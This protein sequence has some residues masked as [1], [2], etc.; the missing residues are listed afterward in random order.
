MKVRPIT[1]RAA[2]EFVDRLHRH[3]KRPQG[4]KFSLCLMVEAVMVGVVMVG[5]PVSRKCDDGLT[6]EV[7]RLCTDGTPNAASKLYGAARRVCGAMGYD[8]VLTFTLDS[9][10]GTSLFAA[11]WEQVGVTSGKSW[12]VASRPRV[13][14]HKLEPRKKWSANCA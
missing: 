5:R 6:A 3:H 2:C 10:P 13:D 11:G 12:N 14:K 4:H 8:R 9:E 1:Y 7:I